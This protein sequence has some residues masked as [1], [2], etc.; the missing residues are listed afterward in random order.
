MVYIVCTNYHHFFDVTPYFILAESNDVKTGEAFFKT[1]VPTGSVE[2]QTHI[3]AYVDASTCLVQKT[4]TPISNRRANSNMLTN[5]RQ[6]Q[7]GRSQSQKKAKLSV[8]KK[9]DSLFFLLQIKTKMK[10]ETKE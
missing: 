8:K 1:H 2:N 3:Q 7:K 5:V 9:E 6:T 4:S 10:Q